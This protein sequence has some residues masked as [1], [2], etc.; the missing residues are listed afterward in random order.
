MR[1]F[2]TLIDV[3]Y[4]AHVKIICSAPKE[5]LSLYTPPSDG[6]NHVLVSSFL[7]L[8]FFCLKKNLHLYFTK[9]KNLV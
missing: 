2:I 8:S 7:F 9:K 6:G 5:I 4:E 1:R 3:L